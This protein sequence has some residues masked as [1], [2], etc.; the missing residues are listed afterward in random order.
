MK[1]EFHQQCESE[2]HVCEGA[3]C[4]ARARGLSLTEHGTEYSREVKIRAADGC[5]IVMYKVMHTHAVFGSCEDI[6]NKA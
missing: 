2:L 1:G 6:H 4:H 3:R 5:D